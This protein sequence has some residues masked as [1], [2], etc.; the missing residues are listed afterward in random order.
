VT[1]PENL[2]LKPQKL[3]VS[4]VS[5]PNLLRGLLLLC[6][7]PLMPPPAAGGVTVKNPPPRRH[8]LKPLLAPLRLIK[9]F[10]EARAHVGT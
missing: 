7:Q 4:A 3:P 9:L 1:E 6:R 10:F 5:W 8:I 2:K